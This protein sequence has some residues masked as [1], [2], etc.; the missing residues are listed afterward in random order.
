MS[1]KIFEHDPLLKPYEEDINLRMNNYFRTKKAILTSGQS[2]S[3]FANGHEYF[4]F[5]KT[6][7][8]WFYREWAP[9]AE[10]VYLTGDFNDWQWLSLPLKKGANGVWEVFIDGDKTLYNGCHVKT[11]VKHDGKLL[12]RIPLY[13]R[14]VEQNP[15][16]HSWCGVIVDLPEYKWKRKKFTPKKN[17]Y[18]YEC[19]VGMAQEDLKV[20]TYKEFCDNVL[21]RIKNAG[22]NTIQIMAIMEHPYY[23]SFGYQ[24][25]S[26]FAPSS[27]YGTQNELKELIDK[28]HSLGI[29]VLLDVVHSHAIK[30]TAEGINEF[31]GTTYQFFHEGEKGD[32][33]AWGT[34][35]F[36]YGKHEV[37]HFLLSNL[38]YW[39]TEFK[40]DGFRFDGVTSMIYHDHG[41]GSA[42]TDYSKYFSLNTHSEAI[43]YL[44]LATDLIKEVN[45]NAIIIAEDMSAMPGMCLPVCEGGVGF[46]Y[47]LAMGTP[48]LWIKLIKE[49][50]DEF[51]N[52][53]H[54]W[55]ELTS[56][57]PNE[58]YIGYA[59]SH[60]QALV[61]DK[62]IIFRLCDKEMY[63]DMNKSSD[64]GVIARGIALHKM[65]RL[66]TLSAGGEGYLNFMGNEFGHPEWIDFPR[67]GNGWSY[68]YC[69]RQWHLVEDKNL[70]YHYLADFDK[71]ILA[72]CKK[73]RI[74]T[75]PAKAL[76]I[77]GDKQVLVY[78]RGGLTF[79]FNFSPVNS[80]EGY[81]VKVAQK[82]T[83]KVALSSDDWCYG[84]YGRVAHAVEYQSQKQT[85]GDNE[86]K[87]YLPTRTAICLIKTNK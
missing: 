19:H 36:N 58:K 54:I 71:D 10:E 42:F 80:Y 2:L 43:T 7:K 40:F 23:G 48:D 64:N 21:P 85:N 15:V 26:F 55:H 77:D 72:L 35:L 67:E 61:G 50:P 37:I 24:V 17:L 28:A 6:D 8:G 57:R 84:G 11:I 66:V 3:D 87:I 44:Q 25:S 4:G 79:L 51:W 22:Y 41:L 75:K 65:I 73:R 9:A 74:F 27:K 47:R 14:R 63:T 82:G 5:H 83:Y 13:I 70:K 59:E 49:Q 52:V 76:Y 34:K 31:D 45:P 1:Y 12:E 53:W 16:D 56:R 20:G 32:H 29:A 68:F 81:T 38:K 30:N 78:K 86:L 69:R 18:I 33:P 60:D 62:T 46:D 39:L